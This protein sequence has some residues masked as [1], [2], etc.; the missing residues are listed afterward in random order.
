M[1]KKM[2][3]RR[4]EPDRD[5]ETEHEALDDRAQ[6]FSPLVASLMACNGMMVLNASM[7]TTS[8]PS[9]RDSLEL[10][11]GL[12]AWLSTAY[13]LPYI[14]AMS[15]YGRLGDG[16]R[17]RRLLMVGILLFL[18]GSFVNLVPGGLGLLLLG[19]AVQGMGAAAVLPLSIALISD[20]FPKAE[21]GRM[22]GTWTSIG[23]MSYV[24]GPLLAGL[25]I[26]ASSWRVIF[27]PVMAVAV[28]AFAA[29]RRWVP[30]KQ[31]YVPSDFFAG[32]DWKGAALLSVAMA[33]L[34]SFVYSEQITGVETLRD[35]R[36][37]GA[38]PIL[39][40]ALLLWEKRH[41]DPFIAPELFRQKTFNRA[42][43]CGALRMFVLSAT[44][45]VMPLYLAD[46][47]SMRPALIGAA[48]PLS[49]VAQAMTTRLGG[50][51]ADRR[52]SREPVLAGLT[53][54]LG[55]MVYFALLPA[56]AP[57]GFVILGLLF[58][59]LA[60]GL[61][62]APMH[63]TAMSE[64]DAGRTGMAAGVYSMLRFAGIAFGSAVNGVL[65]GE[66]LDAGFAPAGAY[67]IVFWTNAGV[68]LL[69]LLVGLSL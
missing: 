3:D 27:A 12:V 30:A 35:W 46:I 66:A 14:V 23:P 22:M 28:A 8:L 68:A 43:L 54:Q 25:L 42:S 59:G 6:R 58:C 61:S 53:G 45:F 15:L 10:E 62:L 41:A 21:R 16:L 26:E 51:W 34:V 65:V 13:Y 20:S 52:H 4:S 11:I 17:R 37:L 40:G 63:R 48:L 56:D 55:V 31:R 9:I 2:T 57:V 60:A 7:V 5:S 1:S 67:Q 44:F 39:F 33:T 24:I 18:L 32:F 19:R 36:L 64:I 38:S 47:R 49:S 29:V 69:G 50:L